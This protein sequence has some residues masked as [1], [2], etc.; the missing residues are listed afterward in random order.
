MKILLITK[1][2]FSIFS[3][4]IVFIIIHVSE[5]SNNLLSYFAVAK[6]FL[7]FELSKV[8][9]MLVMIIRIIYVSLLDKIKITKN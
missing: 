3:L 4:Q 1:I 9:R 6:I 5:R 8:T 7:F 2:F